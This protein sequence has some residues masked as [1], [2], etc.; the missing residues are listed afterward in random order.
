[1]QATIFSG[2]QRIVSTAFARLILIAVVLACP[3]AMAAPAISG[4]TSATGS[5]TL[6]WNAGGQATLAL[7]ERTSTTN[8]TTIVPPSSASSGTQTLTRSPGTY[9]YRIESLELRFHTSGEPD[10]VV[11]YGPIKTVVVTSVTQIEI[12][13]IAEQALYE[14]EVRSG[15]F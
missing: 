2:S 9:E 5:F 12:D 8:W 4:P 1:M 3:T 13:P 15:D 11:T 7:Q 10:Y 14:W 6:I